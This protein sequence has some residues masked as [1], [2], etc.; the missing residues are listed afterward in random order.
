LRGVTIGLSQR[1]PRKLH[2]DE[3]APEKGKKGENL[4]RIVGAE[5]R[6]KKNNN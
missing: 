3:N 2:L 4:Y 5:G 6:V 1:K